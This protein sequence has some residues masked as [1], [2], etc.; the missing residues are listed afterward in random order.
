MGLII[1]ISGFKY[2]TGIGYIAIPTDLSREAYI[3]DCYKNLHV[4][5]KTEDGG[6]LNR[7]PISPEILNFIDF[8]ETPEANGT[9]VVY[10]TDEQYQNTF[11]I[12]RFETRD[13]IGDNRE[14]RFTF[15]RKYNGQYAEISGSSREAMVNI[16]VNGKDKPGLFKVSVVD[17]NNQSSLDVEVAGDIK[18]S[19]TGD[20]VFN[21][22]QFVAESVSGDKAASFKQTEGENKFAGERFVINDGEQ[23][24]VL[25]NEIKEL[26]RN[27]ILEVSKATAAGAPLSNAIQIA[28][29]AE[30]L[31][32]FL[33]KEAFIK[34]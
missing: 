10:N 31:N 13:E 3:N 23:P 12:G 32:N 33:S 21:Q 25:G 14:H 20:V 18:A 34:Q 27:F 29:Y 5:I 7:V 17:D 26:L 6:F 16:F 4:S 28:Q 11:I 15:K 8:P 2:N 1:P 24:M 19:V 22:K 30:Q 9:C